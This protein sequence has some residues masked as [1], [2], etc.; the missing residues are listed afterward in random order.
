MIDEEINVPRGSDAGFLNKVIQ[1]YMKH[2]SFDKPKPK[3][4]NDFSNCFGVK[5]YA[6]TVYYNVTHFLEKDKDTLHPDISGALSTSSSLFIKGLFPPPEPT[7]AGSVRG[8]RLGGRGGGGSATKT[9]GWQFKSQL[10][11]LM[12]TLNATFPHFVRCMK[13]NSLKQGSIF[14]SEM[15]LNQLRYAGL[16]EVC[17]IRKLGF[18]IRRDFDEF[19]KLW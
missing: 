17:R 9:L 3:S 14:E 11:S 8:G 15:M 7:G 13:P 5:H 12:D 18:P 19:Y 4:C 16:L 10:A 6:G 2:E 1:K